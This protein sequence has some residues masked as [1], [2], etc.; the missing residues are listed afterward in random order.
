LGLSSTV[1]S[2]SFQPTCCD[3]PEKTFPL[4]IKFLP[5]GLFPRL[6][7][8]IP[9]PPNGRSVLSSSFLHTPP[10]SRR[11]LFFPL[12]FATSPP[13]FFDT[14]ASRD[15]MPSSHPQLLFF[16][17]FPPLTSFSPLPSRFHTTRSHPSSRLCW[18]RNFRVSFHPL[19]WWRAPVK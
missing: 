5:L 11:L 12:F 6:F 9:P 14:C 10:E 1:I 2:R 16:T 19:I 18:L 3:Y 4:F 8:P 15:T 17:S 7:F 13:P